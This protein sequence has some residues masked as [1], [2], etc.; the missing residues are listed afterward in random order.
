ME[1]LGTHSL[2]ATMLS[3]MAKAGCD[4]SLRRLAGYHTDP[5]ARMPLE[6][7]RDGQ[8]P[9][10]HALQAIGLAIQNGYFDPDA[11]RARRWPR[12]P[13]VTLEMAMTDMSKMA[14]E[15]G[16]YRANNR[17]EPGQ[18]D[19]DDLWTHEWELVS[20]CSEGYS[21]SEPADDLWA[22]VES[23]SSIS[24][25]DERPEFQG[26]QCNTSDEEQEAEVAAP[27]VGEALA[28]ELEQVIQVRVFKHLISGCCHIA[29][30][31]DTDPDD[32]DA[33]VLKC[34]KLASR[35]FEE[36]EQAGNFLPYKCS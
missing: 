15:D 4:L 34:G 20:P 11:S 3:M 33:V 31:M 36:V 21:Q 19:A 22:E 24:D 5:G 25:Q 27:I 14:T 1:L 26:L 16:W 7:S 12:K 10:L 6:Y 28:R 2:K 29:K 32:G 17:T 13:C 35:N 8:A 23:I 18:Q 30:D 9:V